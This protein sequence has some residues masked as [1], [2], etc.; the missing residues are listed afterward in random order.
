MMAFLMGVATIDPATLHAG[1]DSA[2]P[3]IFDVNSR[4]SWLAAHIPGASHLDPDGFAAT[5]L[6]ATIDRPL[7]FYC[8]NP[9][10]RKAPRAARRA[11]QMG[12]RD[13]RVLA[14]GISGWSAAGYPVETGG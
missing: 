7:V 12:Y 10:C 11:R 9:F 1:L 2:G 5:D 8:A 4:A 3:A 6:P 13:V 14:A